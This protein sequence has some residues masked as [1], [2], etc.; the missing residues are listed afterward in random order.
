MYSLSFPVV[1]DS[2]NAVLYNSI[3]MEKT[4]SLQN[5]SNPPK[6][7]DQVRGEI[8]LRHFSYRTEQS[9]LY[10]IRRFILH[11]GLTAQ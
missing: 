1:L 6:L 8:R 10:W 7:L 3:S 4:A 9:Y 11:W 2:I 5:A